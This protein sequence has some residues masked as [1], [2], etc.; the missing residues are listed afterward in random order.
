VALENLSDQ[1]AASALFG[2]F[3]ELAASS[4]AKQH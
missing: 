2:L 1:K 4:S 3:R